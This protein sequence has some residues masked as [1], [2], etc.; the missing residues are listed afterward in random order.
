[1]PEGVRTDAAGVPSLVWATGR[2]K[3][4]GLRLQVDAASVHGESAWC[5]V[6]LPGRRRALGARQLPF[7]V[8]A[9]VR[10]LAVDAGPDELPVGPLGRLRVICDAGE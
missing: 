8:G 10:T 6:E 9:R 5:R 3:A 7:R 4:A 1:L 2:G